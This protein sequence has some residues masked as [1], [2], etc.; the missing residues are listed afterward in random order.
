MPRLS[1]K[2]TVKLE[3]ELL[4]ELQ[5]ISEYEGHTVSRLVRESV[6]NYVKE[7]REGYGSGTIRLNLSRFEMSVVNDLVKIGYV[8]NAEQVFHEAFHDQMANHG[9]GKAMEMASRIR[10]MAPFKGGVPSSPSSLSDQA[11]KNASKGEEEGPD[12]E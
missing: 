7:R 2:I 8:D 9:M 6:Y 3:P 11:L 12:D 1:T 5:L 10:D 4:Q